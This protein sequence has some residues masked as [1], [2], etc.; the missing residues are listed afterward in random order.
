MNRRNFIAGTL[1]AVG[2]LSLPRLRSKAPK[3]KK[4]TRLR[5]TVELIGKVDPCPKHVARLGTVNWSTKEGNGELQGFWVFDHEKR[6]RAEWR[7]K[8][9]LKTDCDTFTAVISKAKL[10]WRRA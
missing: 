1:T 8:R 4:P 3:K 5:Y 10:K 2:G 9:C 6:L 7:F